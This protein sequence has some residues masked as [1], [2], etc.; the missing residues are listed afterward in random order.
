MTQ[1][2]FGLVGAG[3]IAQ[4]YAQAFGVSS[5]AKLVAVADVRPD[6]AQAMAES[7]KCV[8]FGSYQ[9]MAEEM[10]LDAVIICTP[11]ITHPEIVCY[12]LERK[13]H[14]LCEKP[15]SID[16]V[17]A[18]RMYD[19]AE[20][21]GVLVTM[22]SKFRYVADMI[23]AKSIVASGI[24]GDIVLMENAFT[25]RVDMTNRWNSNPAI[26]G[27]G[28][29]MDNG[30]HSLDILRYFLGGLAEVQVVEGKRLQGLS[31][32]DTVRIFVKSTSGVIGNV[33]LSWSINKEQDYFLRVY[34]TNGTIS[35]GW[36]ESKYRQASSPDWVVFGKGYDKVQAFGSQI[37]NFAGA[38]RGK[39][40]LIIDAEDAIASVEAIEAAYQA[41]N[42]SQWTAISSDCSRQV[43]AL[44]MAPVA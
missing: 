15:F 7:A 8:S 33:D 10:D 14:V 29:L 27:G 42:H 41:L 12:F 17:S 32:E 39:E 13:I 38:I 11:P 25:S 36:R 3:G 21:Q 23:K 44:R 43:H 30:T 20:A 5:A 22:A 2:R 40:A 1:V 9:A 18:R 26:S 31:V 34:G 24:L 19:V 4:A 35:V 37:D 28:V 6:A 16:V